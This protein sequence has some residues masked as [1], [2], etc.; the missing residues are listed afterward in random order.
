MIKVICTDPDAVEEEVLRFWVK[1]HHILFTE[2]HRLKYK[3]RG[4]IIRILNYICFNSDIRL[5]F[6]L[7]PYETE[8]IQIHPLCPVEE[9]IFKLN[10]V[11]HVFRRVYRH[12]PRFEAEIKELEGKLWQATRKP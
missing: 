8:Y 5:Y 9:E 12:Y 6:R 10:Y 11:L 3:G 1:L 7:H 2:N 4:Q